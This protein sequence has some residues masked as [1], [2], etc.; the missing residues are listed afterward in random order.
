[1]RMLVYNTL[2]F[3]WLQQPLP[4]TR[5]DPTGLLQGDTKPLAW[6]RVKQ[7]TQ[8][9]MG[10]TLLDSNKICKLAT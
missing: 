2:N 10:R 3:Q 5:L 7:Q 4:V 9:W 1:L 6:R 8:R